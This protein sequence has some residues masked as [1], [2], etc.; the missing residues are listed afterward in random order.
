MTWATILAVTDGAA[1]SDVA[2]TAAIDLGQRFGARANFLHVASD[3]RDLL[4]YVSE[5]MSATALDQV[6]A[7][8]EAGNAR[9]REAVEA[10]FRRLCADLPKVQPEET[11]PAGSFAV[12]LDV[13]TGR[14]PELIERLGR[15]ADVIV[16]PHPALA[17]TDESVSI[18]AA[19][20]GTGRPV[21]VVPADS[22]KD[23]GTR[24]A[25][26]W[27]GSREG[28]LAAAAALPLLAKADEVV[29]VTARE[30]DDVVE[31]SALARYLGSHGIEAKS[32]S[33]T[34]GGESIAEGLLEQVG[35][36]GADCLVMGAYGHS[37]LRERILGGATEG[38]LQKA[39]FPV[40]MMH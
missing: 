16:M 10:S 15:L 18:D 34:P 20:F 36:A 2:M 17:E 21:I 28:A 37:R 35:R 25:V 24:M 39:T 14:Q 13:V 11:V 9:R 30:D 6:M 12:S 22:K 7:S 5:G 40:L 29:V 4:P 19:L 3:S 8:V 1:G 33:F 23:F 32:W 26:A 31:P 38:V 27:D